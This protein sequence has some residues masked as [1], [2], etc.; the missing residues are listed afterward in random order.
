MLLPWCSDIL[1]QSWYNTEYFCLGQIDS[2]E[3]EV[4]SEDNELVW[5]HGQDDP[6]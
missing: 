5:H 4:I 2:D 3:K 6:Q 1:T